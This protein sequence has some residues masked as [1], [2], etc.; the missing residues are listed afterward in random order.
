MS[1]KTIVKT[2]ASDMF[3]LSVI[4]YLLTLTAPI[5]GN[6]INQNDFV[7]ILI[8][9]VIVMAAWIFGAWGLTRS[10]KKE[11]GFDLL[12]KAA[13]PS[14]LQW[15]LASLATVAF[16]AY[17]II[18]GA[19]DYSAAFQSLKTASD[20]VYFITYYIMNAVQACVITLIIAFA[21]KGGDMAIGLGKYIPY[22]GIALGLCRAIANLFA[23]AEYFSMDP[24]G[25]LLSALWMLIYGIV[26]GVI[27]LLIGK[28][29]L[30]AL[31]FIAPAF[32]LM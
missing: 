24:S 14:T 29:P 19:D 22:G 4:A 5:L 20:Y 13:K 32:V 28:K 26:F 27:Y 8:T 11:C 6:F 21:Q 12:D 18:D 2:K 10:S 31:I 3:F 30:Y 25:F 16:I 23:N 15:V 17:C 9:R 1:N 7:A